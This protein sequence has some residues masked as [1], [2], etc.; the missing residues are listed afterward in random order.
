MFQYNEDN[1][2][3]MSFSVDEKWS[4]ATYMRG[5]KL[6]SVDGR[7]SKKLLLPKNVRNVTKRPGVSSSLVLSAGDKYAVSGIRKELYIWNMETEELSKV[8]YAHF[9]RIID[10]KSL[11]VGKENSVITAS[12]DRSIKVWD[13]NYIFE[14]DHHIDKHELTIESVSVS[15]AASLAVTATRG[16][17]GVWDYMTGTLNYTLAKNDMGAIV[18]HAIVNEEGTTVMAAE[19]GEL[20]FWSLETK[21]VIFSEECRGIVQIIFNKKQT[22]CL[23]VQSSGP[24][25]SHT[26][27]VQTKHFP[28][29][30]TDVAFE[31]TYR[32]YVEVVW[33]SDESYIVCYGFE[34]LKNHL[35]VHSAKTGKLV[36]KF[37]V[38][39]DGFKEVQK[40][41]VLPEKAGIVGLIDVDKGNIMDVINK[42]LVKSIQGWG[43]NCTKDGKF[44]LCAPPSGG[45]DILDLRSGAVTKTLIPKI[46]EG[47]FDVIAEFN[48]RDDYILY[49]HSGR[50][51][52]RAFRRKDGAQIAN[53]RVQAEMKAMKT[54]ADGRS[55]ILGMGD[56]SMTTLT[57]ADPNNKDTK[58]YL[59]NLPSRILRTQKGFVHPKGTYFQNGY[60]YP[61]PYDYPIYTDYL[62]DLKKVIPGYKPQ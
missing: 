6:W 43:G 19:S 41:V 34:K 29:G 60:P 2:L 28:S 7:Q 30:E 10:I 38:K 33:T 27:H 47:I 15:S 56:G 36:H 61:S 3:M 13:L 11:V 52:I 40:M 1:I 20:L 26:G 37:L 50:K 39:Y 44:G 59:N 21:S 22:K 5:F 55:I 48:K 16:C 35:Y 24:M 18:T 17:I 62:K 54:S 4:I 8:L 9:Q 51:T 42:K 14:D 31:Y 58:N 45:M 57:I 46:S 12:I 32:K 53:Y 25:G 49:Y 23:V